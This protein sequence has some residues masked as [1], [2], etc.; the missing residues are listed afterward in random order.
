MRE[1]NSPTK[2]WSVNVSYVRVVP[3]Q[4][5]ARPQIVWWRNRLWLPLWA[6]TLLW[7]LIK[8]DMSV[9]VL[10]IDLAL[11]SL[12]YPQD[13]QEEGQGWEEDPRQPGEG[14]LGRPSPCGKLK[15]G[16]KEGAGAKL[17][18]GGGGA[19]LRGGGGAKVWRSDRERAWWKDK[20]CYSESPVGLYC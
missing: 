17:R 20:E 7:S 13:R 15:G 8:S 1:R 12:P 16:R 3:Y 18:G 11:S 14:I 2:H 5:A 19:K 6:F 10:S 9:C 4:P